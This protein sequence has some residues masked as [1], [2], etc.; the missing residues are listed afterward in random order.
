MTGPAVRLGSFSHLALFYRTL[1]EYAA[2]VAAFL[3]SGLIAGE[4]ALVAVPLAQCGWLRDA[5]GAQA[6]D[7]RFEDITELG[8]NPAWIIPRVRE[9]VDAYPGQHVRYVGEPIWPTRT[10]PEQREVIRHEVLLDLA[11]A[12]T[13]A[14]ILCPYD[15]TQLAPAVIADAQR[16]HPALVADGAT[17]PSPTYAGIGRMPS[18]T[19]TALAPPPA[20]AMSLEYTTDLTAVRT[21]VE[22]QARRFG[23][24]EMRIIDLVLAVS[25]VAANTIKHARSAGT[26]DISSRDREIV[27]TIRDR[28]TITD[29]LA[30][31]RRPSP[32]A[33]DGHGL[34]LVQQVCDLVEIRSDHSGTTIRM[35]MSLPPG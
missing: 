26:L 4:P 34:W 15:T 18:S 35:H 17:A 11:F 5:L 10:R 7:V 31:R 2:R 21:E 25:E 16:T 30:G 13:D 1:D 6:G 33:S 12:E 19:Q 32:D 9:F 29:P 8:R 23:L 24:P 14:A 3:R 28:G 27:C 22:K 20:D